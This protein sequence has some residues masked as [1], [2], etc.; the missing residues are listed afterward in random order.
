VVTGAAMRRLDLGRAAEVSADVA[1]ARSGAELGDLL[2]RAA[3]VL[4]A[5][6]AI[7]WIGAGDE[8]LPAAS[9]GFDSQTLRAVGPL[10]RSTRNATVDAWNSES[11]RTVPRTS[12]G[13]GAIVAP[14]FGESRCIGV[15]AVEVRDGRESDPAIQATAAM[16]AAQ[17]SSIM[18]TWRPRSTPS[19]NSAPA[20]ILTASEEDHDD[21]LDAVVNS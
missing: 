10:D 20:D 16:F 11:I 19:T 3:E 21:H 8:L 17:F 7:L 4:N 18:P 13:H 1:R 15:L 2:G 14:L 12:D 9:S 6:G 5:P